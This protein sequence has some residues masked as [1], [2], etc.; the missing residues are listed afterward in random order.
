MRRIGE[1][2]GPAGIFSI[3]SRKNHGFT[4]DWFAACLQIVLPDGVLPR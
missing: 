3:F 2:E 1:R 4:Q